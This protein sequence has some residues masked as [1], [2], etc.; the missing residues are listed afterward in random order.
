LGIYISLNCLSGFLTHKFQILKDL[1]NISPIRSVCSGSIGNRGCG[2]VRSTLLKTETVLPIRAN[3]GNKIAH[4]LGNLLAGV[5]G[6]RLRVGNVNFDLH[7]E[8]PL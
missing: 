7:S 2:T 5:E 1:T 8:S 3:Q 6:P 4:Y